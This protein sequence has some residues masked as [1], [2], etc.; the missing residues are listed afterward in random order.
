VG[1]KKVADKG[2]ESKENPNRSS[3]HKRMVEVGTVLVGDALALQFA[4][5][6]SKKVSGDRAG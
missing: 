2:S 5:Q 4:K 3:P 1:A 6:F